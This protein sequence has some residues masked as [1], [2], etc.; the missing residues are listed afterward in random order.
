MKNKYDRLSREEK[1]AA[2]KEFTLAS[3]KNKEIISRLNRLRFVGIVGIIYSSIMF[4]LDFL[5]EQNIFDY[6][7]NTFDNI[8]V[9]YLIDAFLLIMCVIFLMKA[10]SMKKEQ[11]NK[12]LITKK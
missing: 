8:F 1:K 2:I 9:S 6:G 10:I 4:I 11:V 3:E 5:K 7:F 12:Y